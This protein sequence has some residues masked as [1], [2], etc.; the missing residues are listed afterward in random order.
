MVG[1]PTGIRILDARVQS[2][3][4][5]NGLIA[6]SK[7]HWSWPE[8]YLEK[9]LPL[10][11]I[12]TE[13]LRTNHCF[14]VYFGNAEYP[15]GFVGGIARSEHFF[16]PHFEHRILFSTSVNFASQPQSLPNVCGSAVRS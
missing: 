16:S 8:G 7:A 6:H 4:Q 2:L 12:S 3:P 9:A 10:H 5:I 15:R 14:E 11:T 13:Y 1:A